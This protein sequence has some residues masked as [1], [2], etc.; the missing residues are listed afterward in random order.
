MVERGAEACK[1]YELHIRRTMKHQNL[2]LLLLYL[3][4]ANPLRPRS[5][6]RHL[7]CGRR[8]HCGDEA[9]SA[10]KIEGIVIWRRVKRLV[11]CCK[12]AGANK[13]G[14]RV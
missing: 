5:A 12:T 7:G 8:S 6:I 9:T 4:F 3:G 2:D 11:G 10:A 1:G 14:K 13:G